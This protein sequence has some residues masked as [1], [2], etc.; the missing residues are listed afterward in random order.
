M[1]IFRDDVDHVEFE[2]L[3]ST[4]V[5]EKRL[6]C[7]AVVQMGNHIHL[8]ATTIEANLS[9]AMQQLDK[10]YA[11]F[12]NRRHGHV[13]HVFQGRFHAQIVQDDLYLLS[14][15]RYVVRNPVRAALVPAPEAWRWSSYRAAAGFA[16]VPDYLSPQMVWHLIGGGDAA[17]LRFREFVEASPA[18][19]KLPTDPVL[20]DHDFQLRFESSR[21]KA[22]R[23]VARR[24]RQWKWPLDDLFA[25]AVTPSARSTAVIEARTAGYSVPE[26]AAYLE[27]H[28]NTVRRMVSANR[29]ESAVGNVVLA[30]S[31]AAS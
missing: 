28:A 27:V 9:R 5:R 3:L 19:D 10:E 15:C 4:V 21:K 29:A 7:H 1:S 18:D 23:E 2:D 8:V 16:Q 17:P 31:L 12:W 22:S 25:L 24:E 13:G 11:E 20:G 30:P 14:A 26:I 6:Q